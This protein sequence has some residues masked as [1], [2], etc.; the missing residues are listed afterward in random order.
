[1]ATVLVIGASRGI[2]FEFVRQYRAAGDTVIATARDAQ[3][4]ARLREL[5][6][7]AL[8]LDVNDE[9]SQADFLGQLGAPA[10]D[11]ALYVAGV[12]P[13]PDARTPPQ[14]ADFDHAM[15]TNVL[16]AMQLLPRVAPLVAAAPRGRFAFLSSE[17]AQIATLL[18]DDKTHVYIC[19]LKGME[20]GVDE[21][22]ADACRAASIDWSSLKPGM[23][24]S[25]RY[26]VETY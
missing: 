14:R 3:G 4:L 7:Q 22:F 19:G 17:M 10:L 15:H 6:A 12:F 16:A 2:G 25:G 11:I 8:A 5:G 21:A 23:R 20:T 24:E 1:M 18:R 9:A 26:H 13:L